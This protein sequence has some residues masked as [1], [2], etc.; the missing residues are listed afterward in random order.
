MSR[1]VAQQ[2][3]GWYCGGA[4]RSG[5]LLGGVAGLILA[6]LWAFTDH[7]IAARN[8]NILQCSLFALALALVFPFARAGR[9]GLLRAT[10]LLAICVGGLSVLGLMIKLLPVFSQANGQILALFVPANLGLSLGIVAWASRRA[11]PSA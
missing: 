7:V 2:S 8:E 11:D 5:R 9:P 4:E 1:R 3:R 10:R 6:G